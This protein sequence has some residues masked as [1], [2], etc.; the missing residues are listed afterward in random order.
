MSG[1]T[2]RIPHRDR[3]EALIDTASNCRQLEGDE[4]AVTR[5]I[6]LD[7]A[8]DGLRIAGEL[9]DRLDGLEPHERRALL[10]HARVENGL[11]PTGEVEA[12]QRAE[13]ATKAGSARAASDSPYQLCHATGC[14]ALP[15]NALGVPIPVNAVRWFCA[16]HRGEAR[17]GDMDPRPAPWRL[18]P[19]GA[20]VE[21]NPREDARQAAAI[22][23]R[24]RQRESELADR[25]TDAAA[26]D[27]YERAR[28]EQHQRDLPA[29]LKDAR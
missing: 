20:I 19:S 15:T 3:D 25:A 1:W 7:A 24:A 22:E 14:N 17:P 29:H 4:S 18:S 12:V 27:A 2:I 5:T 11:P 16:E 28:R 9:L 26:R 23:S 10:D 21:A 13:V 6:V 8:V